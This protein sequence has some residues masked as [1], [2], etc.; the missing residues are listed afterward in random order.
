MLIF[1]MIL[2]EV[3]TSVKHQTEFMDGNTPEETFLEKS[4][5]LHDFTYDDE[6]YKWFVI[7]QKRNSIYLKGNLIFI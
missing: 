2:I 3:S 7:K 6:R 5:I 1:N 4:N